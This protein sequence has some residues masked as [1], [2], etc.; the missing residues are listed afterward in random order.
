[1]SYK[2]RRSERKTKPNIRYDPGIHFPKKRKNKKKIKEVKDIN[3]YNEWLEENKDLSEKNIN[4]KHNE[5]R[6]NITNQLGKVFLPM[7][8]QNLSNLDMNPKKEFRRTL[9][10][11][12]TLKKGL[13][14]VQDNMIFSRDNGI[15]LVTS[16]DKKQT[17]T[18][19]TTPMANRLHYT[20]NCGSKF[21]QPDRV[22]C[23][24]IFG[25][26]LYSMNSVVSLFYQV[27][28]VNTVQ[29]VYDIER[30]VNSMNMTGKSTSTSSKSKIPPGN[31]EMDYFSLLNSN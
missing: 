22:T 13:K 17:Y 21:K 10:L 5:F 8:T 18:V 7:F 28:N 4:D 12:E 15:F 1:M 3:T 31:H 24:H 27:S 29:G 11:K 26:I 6:E 2:P 19:R 14:L 23:K 9:A 16:S 30:L 25:V 20:C